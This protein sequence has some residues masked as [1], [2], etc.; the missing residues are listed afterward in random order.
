MKSHLIIQGPVYAGF[1]K[2]YLPYDGPEIVTLNGKKSFDCHRAILENARR[3]R[4]HFDTIVL[5]IWDDAE[6]KNRR[7]LEDLGVRIVTSPANS[8]AH[9]PNYYKQVV[10][11]LAGHAALDRPADDDHVLK[12]RTDLEF[13]LLAFRRHADRIDEQS[14]DWQAVGQLGFIHAPHSLGP[15][16]ISDMFLYARSADFHRIWSAA[17]SESRRVSPISI[18]WVLPMEYA[19]HYREQ[20]KIPREYFVNLVRWH[21]PWR[22]STKHLRQGRLW[23]YLLKHCFSFAPPMLPE[24]FVWRGRPTTQMMRLKRKKRIHFFEEWEVLRADEDAVAR[25]CDLT[26]FETSRPR[27][28]RSIATAWLLSQRV[29]CEIHGYSSAA[30]LLRRLYDG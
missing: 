13:D 1:S 24:E 7:E 4:E 17:R 2:D 14:P 3:Y 29:W 27:R 23:R 10:G 30:R 16:Y 21:S 19:W 22:R 26:Y 20:L 18:H 6:L 15:Y 11:V 12:T 25:M 28:I 9:L 8:V 5:S